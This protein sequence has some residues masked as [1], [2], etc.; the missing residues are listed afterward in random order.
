MADPLGMKGSALLDSRTG[1]IRRVEHESTPEWFPPSFR[2]MTAVLSDPSRWSEWAVDSTGAGYGFGSEQPVRAAAIGEAVERYCGSLPP[3]GLVHASYREL[4]D[5]RVAAV[6][7]DTFALFS[8]RQYSRAGFPFVPFTRELAVDW[9]YGRE[10][11]SGTRVAVPASLVWVSHPLRSGRAGTA[12][13]TNPVIQ[14]GLAAGSDR[15]RAEWNAL[16][17]IV[18]RDTMTAVWSGGGSVRQI[19]PPAWLGRMAKGPRNALHTRF[20]E[21][22]NPYGLVLVGALVHDSRTSYLTM[23]MGCRPDP[24]SALEKAFGEA[25]QLQRFVAAYDDPTGG[26]MRA[27]EL[28]TSPLRPWRAD[29]RYAQSYRPDFTDVVDYGCHLQLYLDPDIQ[30]RFERELA[31]AIEAEVPCERLTTSSVRDIASLVERLTELGYRTVSVDV[32]TPDVAAL[33]WSVVRV[34]VPGLY[35]NGAAGLPLLGGR[36]GDFERGLPLPH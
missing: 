3:A 10:L 17:E 2:F 25:L 16:C 15:A 9:T 14:A 1:I 34:V 30:D 23:G 26:Y 24:G 19:Q 8:E 29:R 35:T 20:L 36:L 13:S 7:P 4:A 12:S 27:A 21:F 32:T 6:D 33:G 18:E 31:D 5:R 11:G 28:P 22:P